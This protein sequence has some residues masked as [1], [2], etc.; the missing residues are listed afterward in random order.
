MK[1]ELETMFLTFM[2][3]VFIA[4]LLG[5]MFYN[6]DLISSIKNGAVKIDEKVYRCEEWKYTKE[7]TK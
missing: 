6:T 5:V 4:S 3:T 1:K 7:K 2:F